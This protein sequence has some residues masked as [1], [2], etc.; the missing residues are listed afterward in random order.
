MIEKQT[1]VY[2]CAFGWGGEDHLKGIIVKVCVCQEKGVWECVAHGA[3]E[4]VHFK[5][6]ESV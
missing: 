5:C 3:E 6:G 4:D 1:C 2:I